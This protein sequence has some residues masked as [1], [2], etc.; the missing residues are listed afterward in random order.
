MNGE[1]TALEEGSASED[2][3]DSA[4]P[5]ERFGADVK[6]VRLGR[7]LTQKHLGRAAGYSVSYVSQ[8]ESGK[9]LPSQRFAEGC[10][11]LFG[12]N[13]L[14]TGLLRRI[15]EGD[16][17]AQFV[18]YVHLERKAS[19]VHSFSTTTV[20]G[21]FQTEDYAWAIFRAGNPHERDDV[22]R[23]KVTARTRRRRIL[24]GE[25]APMVWLV[26]HEACLRTHVGGRFVMAGQLAR[27]T[28]WAERPGIDLQV[29][30]FTTGAASAHTGP[31]TLLSF[32]SSPTVLYAGDPQGGKLYERPATVTAALQ[33]YDRLRAHALP[34]DE[35]LAFIKTV[36]KEYL[37]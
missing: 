9:L 20:M 16:H 17:A 11:M 14:F 32:D 31:F 29:M 34:P 25:R 18:P 27:L 30:P 21:M 1:V 6:R 35:S 4:S 2:F 15:T 33:N 8:V 12:T 13:G 37:S 26:L 22:I 7:G 28:Q 10:D 36:H 23:G 19:H 5:L 24:S 3:R